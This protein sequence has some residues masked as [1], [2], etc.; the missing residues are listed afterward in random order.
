MLREARKKTYEY[1]QSQLPT[2]NEILAEFEA[3]K[4]DYDYDY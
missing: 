4:D 3:N 2:A 1:L